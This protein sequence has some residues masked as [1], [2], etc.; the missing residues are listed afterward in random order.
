MEYNAA[1]KTKMN[2]QPLNT[3]MWINL[4]N[5]CYKHVYVEKANSKKVELY[6][7]PFITF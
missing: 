3:T 2:K 7:T 1:E 5:K 4:R 6:D